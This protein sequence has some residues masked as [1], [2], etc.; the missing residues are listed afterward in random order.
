[1]ST[2]NVNNIL[3][4]S[5]SIVNVNAVAIKDVVNGP[6]VLY[7]GTEYNANTST[8]IGSTIVGNGAMLGS[9]GVSNTAIG[10]NSLRN[11]TTGG[12]NTAVGREALL[13]NVT[14]GGNTAVGY[15]AMQNTTGS[16][17][18]AL[19]WQSLPT[20][21]GQE[22]VAIGASAGFSLTTGSFN[23]IVGTS[24][25][26]DITTGNN[27]IVLG[28]DTQVATPTTSNSITL[29]N[30]SHN[31][32]R[33]AVTSITSLSDERDKKEIEILPVGLDFI[34]SLKPVSFV[35]NERDEKGKHDIKDF[36][37]I[38][39]DLK[40]SQEDVNLA[41]TLKLVYDENPEKLEASYGKL[42]PIL[43]KAIQDMSSKM[44]SLEKEMTNLKNK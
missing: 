4:T 12:S 21:S 43:V 27:N 17:N 2:T 35:W 14:G 8:G 44:E 15:A 32:L 34:N 11:N 33:C 20:G 9:S 6:F 19:G 25:G 23:V 7:G 28:D 42:I 10:A 24:S 36:G 29:G 16:V 3:P 1:M 40:K 31:V 38:A 13:T 5:G 22:N 41:D 37:F 18:T 39:Q 30:G 26:A